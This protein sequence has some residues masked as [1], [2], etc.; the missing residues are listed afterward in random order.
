V[1]S[2]LLMRLLRLAF[3]W[4]AT[5]GAVFGPRCALFAADDP[6]AALFGKMDRAAAKFKDLTANVKKV[7]Y[8][9][10]IKEENVDI[11]TIAVKVP[12]P[13]D[14]HVL[15]D[16]QQPDAKKVMVSGTKVD[17]YYPKTNVDQDVDLGKSHRSQIESFLLLG[18][19]SNSR[20]LQNAYSVKFG[21]PEAVEGQKATRIELF[22]KSKDVATQFP[23]FELWISDDTG[24]SLQQKMYQPGGDYSLL[25]YTNMKLNQN[26]PDS[27]VKLNLPKGVQHEHL[28]K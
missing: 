13:H 15:I 11:G 26:L 25:T 2:P 14:Y 23:E 6:L 1:T 4:I 19:G 16:F 5:A 21:G 7:S 22:P 27:A 3:V 9:A 10:F 28:A 20:E 8:L 18:F 17:L 24:I 12:K